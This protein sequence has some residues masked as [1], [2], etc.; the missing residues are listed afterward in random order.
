MITIVVMSKNIP[1]VTDMIIIDSELEFVSDSEVVVIVVVVV[2]VV[3]V[4]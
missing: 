3:V 1:S 2:V 4:V